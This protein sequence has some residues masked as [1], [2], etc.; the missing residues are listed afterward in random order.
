MTFRLPLLPREGA[1][2]DRVQLSVRPDW[3]ELQTHSLSGTNPSSAN[4]AFESCPPVLHQSSLISLSEHLNR[5][6]E[7]FING[8]IRQEVYKRAGIFE[9][10]FDSTVFHS[11]H[12]DCRIRDISH[13]FPVE[14]QQSGLVATIT[15]LD[16][17]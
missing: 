7:C 15:P 16:L 2:P 10:V 8:Y 13:P 14:R 9:V 12:V 3:A 1:G 17:S 5:F 11:Y 6:P 4:E